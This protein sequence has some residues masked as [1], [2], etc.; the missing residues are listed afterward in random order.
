MFTVMSTFYLRD[1]SVLHNVSCCDVLIVF[2]LL[3]GNLIVYYLF[4]DETIITAE[5]RTVL[6]AILTA[7]G[8]TGVLL[9]I[10]FCQLPVAEANT[11]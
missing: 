11:V 7:A 6:F 1:I 10:F 4:A 8:V 2:S 9:M 3:F 5:S